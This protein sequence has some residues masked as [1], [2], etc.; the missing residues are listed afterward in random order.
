MPSVSLLPVSAGPTTGGDSVVVQGS[1]LTGT[2]RVTFGQ[3]AATDVSVLSDSS[4]Q[5]TAPAQNAGTVDVRVTTLGGASATSLNDH[6]TYVAPTPPPGQGPW[7]SFTVGNNHVCALKDDHTAWCWGDNYYG[8]LGSAGSPT[9][10]AVPRQVGTEAD[11]A[12]LSAGMRNTCGV[13]T[14]GTAWC[15]G[16]NSSGQLG[17]GDNGAGAISPRQVGTGRDWKSLTS[18]QGVTCGLKTTGALWCWG[19]NAIGEVGDGTTQNRWVPTR[20][21]DDSDWVSVS[22][23]MQQSC[24]LKSNGTAWCWGLNNAGAVGDGTTEN[25]TIPTRVGTDTD[26][27]GITAGYLGT[28]GLKTNGSAWC[29]GL[30][31]AGGIGDG[32][33]TNSL[34]PTLVGTS[35]EWGNVATNLETACGVHVDGSAWCWGNNPYGQVGD[36]S[37][38]VRHD[39][40]QVGTGHDWVKVLPGGGASCGLTSEK[41]LWCWG[42][43]DSGDLGN[44]LGPGSYTPVK[45]STGS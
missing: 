9:D 40:T 32:T 25:R 28:C 11:W 36:G 7:A 8:Q 14:N 30:N 38:T 33:T 37:T 34:S 39:P 2:S 35:A 24:A 41:D 27:T 22:S 23:G 12:M 13:K 3:T 4:L 45:V 17:S 44:G 10:H 6:Y 43:N 1:H 16:N 29:W 15:W 20:I 5:V 42:D 19:S 18:G 31:D 21:G 26:W